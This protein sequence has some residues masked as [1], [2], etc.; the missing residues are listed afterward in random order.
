MPGKNKARCFISISD[1]THTEEIIC[2]AV[3]CHKTVRDYLPKLKQVL[4]SIAWSD[5][6]ADSSLRL[7]AVLHIAPVS[8]RSSGGNSKNAQGIYCPW[9]FCF[10]YW[11]VWHGAQFTVLTS[12]LH[13]ITPSQKMWDL[14]N[15]CLL[16][17]NKKLTTCYRK[18]LMAQCI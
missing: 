14:I 5:Q 2:Y 6:I 9:I 3:S 1:Q 17:L 13:L 12:Q 11:M 8:D 10:I 18:W 4:A 16:F 7:R 15:A